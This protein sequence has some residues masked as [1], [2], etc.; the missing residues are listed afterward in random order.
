MQR[1]V[2]SDL[3]QLEDYMS[4]AGFKLK[5]RKIDE[6]ETQPPFA[7]LTFT[8]KGALEDVHNILRT[9]PFLLVGMD[10]KRANGGLSVHLKLSQREV[11]DSEGFEPEMGDA[12]PIGYQ[13]EP[14][15]GE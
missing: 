8:G 10:S 5:A 15:M 1:F 3:T 12:T 4:K 9:S 13:F 14:E 11:R 7:A 6:R 2:A